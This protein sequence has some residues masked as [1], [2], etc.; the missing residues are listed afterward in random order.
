M[1]NEPIVMVGGGVAGIAAAT[2]LARAG[3]RTVLIEQHREPRHKVC[4]EFLSTEACA[5]LKL[6]GIDLPALGAVPV[7][8]VR[9]VYGRSSVEAA[10]PF[11]ALSLTRRCLDEHMLA[12]AAASGVEV[13]RGRRVDALTP[14]AAGADRTAGVLGRISGAARHTLRLSGGAELHAGAVFL[15]TGKHDLRGYARPPVRHS[16]LVAFKQYF[17]LQ[18][19]QQSRLEGAVELHLF[20][21]GYA[22]LQMVEG[23]AANL[24]LLLHKDHLRAEGAAWPRVLERIRRDAPRLAER[25]EGA[26]EMLPQPLA[27]SHIPYGYLALPQDE[28][29]RLG[30]QAAVIPSFTGDG[31]SIALHS[32]RV[33]VDALLSGQTARLGAAQLRRDLRGSMTWAVLLTDMLLNPGVRRLSITVAQLWPGVLA[34]LALATRIPERAREAL[35]QR[36]LA[37]SLTQTRIQ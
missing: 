35:R 37:W 28:V 36:E 26:E 13:L 24:C 12:C 27:L 34:R 32:A 25:L 21:G 7:N 23:D 2:L 4:G 16:G 3:R 8:A 5:S 19:R 15:C 10:L 20:R 18:A 30:D 33:A 14:C 29:W 31:M 17:R 1:R 9:L 11:P 6:L 22:G